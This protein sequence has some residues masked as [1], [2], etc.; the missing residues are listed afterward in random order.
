M[1]PQ[2][3]L[4]TYKRN[5]IENAPPIKVVRMMYQGALRFIDR[6]LECDAADPRSQF[7]HWLYRADAVVAELRLSLDKTKAPQ[8]A[9]SLEQLYL[10]C[11][12]E[13]QRSLRERD[14]SRLAAV[15][16]VLSNLLQAWTEVDVA[17][18]AA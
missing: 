6:A 4:D 11:E 10:F 2:A 7:V 1:N 12:G 5:A 15:R 3:A 8:V 18:A 9:D 16:Q 14:P 13:L 17:E